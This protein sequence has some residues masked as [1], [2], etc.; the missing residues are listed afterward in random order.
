MKDG[1]V[2]DLDDYAKILPSFMWVVRDFALQLTDECGNKISARDY[3]E[4]ALKE[5]K[6][7]SDSAEHKNRIRRLLKAFFQDRDCCTMVRP[8]SDENEL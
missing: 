1:E 3:L 7:V 5:Q 8:V 4:T 2:T 6:G